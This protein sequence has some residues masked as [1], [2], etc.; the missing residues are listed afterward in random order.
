[1]AAQA[2]Y[3]E[4]EFELS[5]AL[6][7]AGTPGLARDGLGPVCDRFVFFLVHWNVFADCCHSLLCRV[8]VITPPEV[9]DTGPGF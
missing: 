5:R 1:M 9:T 7:G 4:L 6:P 2:L 8:H 3:G